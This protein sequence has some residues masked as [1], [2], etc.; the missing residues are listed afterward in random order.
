MK[1]HRLLVIG[2]LAFLAFACNLP[3][4]IVP[5]RPPLTPPPPANTAAANNPEPAAS[6]TP[7]FAPTAA[8]TA[9]SAA[10]ATVTLTAVPS[11]SPTITFTPTPST[12]MVTPLKDPV[13]CRFG[14]SVNYEQ[15][16]ALNVDAFAPITGRSTDGGWWQIKTTDTDSPY[17][18]VADSVVVKS[19][20]LSGIPTVQTPAS[21]ITDLQVQIKPSSAN[22]GLGCVGPFPKFAVTGTITVNGPMKVFWLVE[23]EQDGKLSNHSLSIAKYG[24]QVLTINY[25]PSSW[26]KGTFWVNLIITSPVGMTRG[27]NY[28]ITCQ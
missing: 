13:N 24:S 1:T 25:V 6:Q 10:T 18:W 8:S 9:T 22:L 14:P 15:V 4:E 11:A 26:S 2:L 28:Q 23:T 20:D 19:G 16:F 21:L 27:A 5:A 3:F 12:P 17:C 7:V